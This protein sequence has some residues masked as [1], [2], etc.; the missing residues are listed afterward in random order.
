MKTTAA[1]LAVALTT[2]SAAL[3]LAGCVAGPLSRGSGV[4]VETTPEIPALRAVSVGSAFQVNLRA[5]DEPALVLR[6]DDNLVEQI[7]VDVNDGELSIMLGRTVLDATLEAE[8]T[9]P[10]DALSSVE[11]SGAA[12]ITGTEVL[13]PDR[14]EVDVSGAGRAFLVVEVEELSVSADG[15]SLVNLSGRA[16]VLDAQAVGASSLQ[17]ARLEAT[18]AEVSAEGASRVDVS[19]SETLSAR[20]AGASTVRYSGAP[21]SV[22]SDVSGASSV[23]PG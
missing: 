3:A 15:A 8:I 19:V 20:A 2:T 5:G 18:T 9:V 22:E 13:S 16:N 7:E 14:L 4:V 17:L 23:E 10:A 21:E 6:T 1:A 12:S 11:L